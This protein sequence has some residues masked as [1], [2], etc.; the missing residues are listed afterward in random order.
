MN[1]QMLQA[2]IREWHAKTADDIH[3]VARGYKITNG[4]RTNELS[5]VFMVLHKRPLAELRPAK[6]HFE[7]LDS[8]Y[9]KNTFVC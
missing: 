9:L 3:G 5:I 4:V 6:K 8:I 2:T 7:S 1:N